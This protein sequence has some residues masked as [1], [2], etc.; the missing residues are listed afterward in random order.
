MDTPGGT[1]LLS[2]PPLLPSLLKS[3]CGDS[4]TPPSP[5]LKRRHGVVSIGSSLTGTA[6]G[7]VCACTPDGGR[8]CEGLGVVE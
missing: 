5:V 8:G 3:H 6:Y 7:R 1:L 4:G 2:L